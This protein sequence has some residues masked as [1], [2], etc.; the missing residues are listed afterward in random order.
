MLRYPSTSLHKF[1][2]FGRQ[3]GNRP[4][5]FFF[6]KALYV[7]LAAINSAAGNEEADIMVRTAGNR[8]F[9]LVFSLLMALLLLLSIGCSAK[10]G[11]DDKTPTS[12]GDNTTGTTTAFTPTRTSHGTQD[13]WSLTLEAAQGSLKSSGYSMTT[14]M[15]TPTMTMATMAAPTTAGDFM[16]AS[17]SLGFSTGGAKDIA[18]FRE[19]IKNNYLPLPTDITYE[20]LFYDY[21]FD[22][23]VT[24]PQ[25]KLFYPSY[26][27]A[28]S[29]DPISGAVE[30]YLSVGLNS[31]MKA[32]DFA[33]KKL[34]LVVVL[35]IS[36]SMSSPFDTYYYDQSGHV[37]ELPDEESSKTK[38]QV[39]TESVVALLGHLGDDDS[40][41]MVL[42]NDY[43]YVAK[44]LNPVSE[45]DMDAIENH[46]LHI[47]ADGST[48]LDAGMQTATGLFDDL[49]EANPD[50]YENR[51]IF[52]TDAMPNTG[53]YSQGGLMDMTE[54]NA[55]DHIYSTFIGIGVDFNT[56]LIEAITKIRGANYYSV[57]SSQEFKTRMSDEFDYMVT[58]LVFNLQ[59]NLEASGWDIEEVYGSPE[60]DKSTGELMKVNTLFPS[61]S[62][63]GE[64]RG[65]L[66]LLKLKKTGSYDQINL[67]V[68]YEDRNGH[69]DTATA[70]IRPE[71]FSPDYYANS[72]IRKG[73]LLARYAELLKNW[74]IDERRHVDIHIAWEPCINEDTGIICPPPLYGLSEWERLSMPLTV[75]APY[76]E[77]FSS[78]LDYFKAEALAIGD[79]DL[80]QE[81]DV[82]E[83]L[84]QNQVPVWLE[85]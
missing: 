44:P 25:D 9:Y 13:D 27:S 76:Q 16:Q 31:G 62:E 75:S 26:S 1:Q 30:Y 37:R 46:I 11:G 85:D 82:L 78:F 69:T 83:L 10:P 48:N 56:E 73:I 68:S 21:Y 66:V 64:T 60:A 33:R 35:D 22:T 47:E 58:P 3:F 50:E 41:G 84:L 28:V 51:I 52:L 63:G 29:R 54:D 80:D 45:T 53:D 57:H 6:L 12:T 2:P 72:G 18:N 43:A 19:N 14:G 74:M 79:S 8:I 81:V 24:E 70:V 17:D 23:G 40:F 5:N 65:G 4:A 15:V 42:Y 20:G 71:S 34:N 39:A 36:G 59:L 77:L 7:V 61:K 38:I 49:K 32:S 67:K 55:L